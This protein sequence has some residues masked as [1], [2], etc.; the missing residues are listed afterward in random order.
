MIHSKKLQNLLKQSAQERYDYFIRKVADFESVYILENDKEEME[1]S[2]FNGKISICVYPEEG[3]ANELA[4]NSNFS[5]SEI[6]LD[7]FLNWLDDLDKED[8]LC[9][10]FP[11][12]DDVIY[13]PPLILK[14]HILEECQQYT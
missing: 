10:V 1:T 2:V 4:F 7:D 11:N 8:K 13:A 12:S 6:K 3:I 14:N 5:V 9:A